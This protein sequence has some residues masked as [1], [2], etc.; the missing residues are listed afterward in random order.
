MVRP[1]LFPAFVVFLH[2]AFLLCV[3][4][5]WFSMPARAGVVSFG[6]GSNIFQMEFV[7]VG[8]PGNADDSSGDP[9]PAGGVAYTFG[10]GKYEVSESMIDKFNNSQSLTISKDTRSPNKPATGVS[11]NE[12]ARFVNWLNTSTGGFAAYKF[13]SGG[14]ND[15]IEL[16]SVS[17]SLDFDTMNPFRSKRAK[18][19]LP[20][21]NEWYKAA[22][23]DPSKSG[24]G[25]YWNYGT[26]S[27]S[28]PIAVASGTAPGTAV[29]NQTHQTGPAEVDKAGGLS[30]YGVMALSGN[31]W[32]W[33]ESTLDLTNSSATLPRG[34]RGGYYYG[35][36][37]LLSS[38]F[39]GSFDP[40][41]E[42]ETLAGFRVVSLSIG[43][44][45]VPEPS[46]LIIVCLLSIG[47]FFKRQTP[48][49]LL[50]QL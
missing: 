4:V 46:S 49:L 30:A 50:P 16:W 12:A 41:E 23:Y 3:P 10:I 34:L 13:T 14:V 22:Y 31:A 33:E 44:T 39:R 2:F 28:I 9:N 17:D 8:A 42:N 37:F 6:S 36:H 32:E 1:S 21:Y 7:S 24:V 43:N 27:D 29:F 47:V 5:F 45:A 18:Y 26:A 19:V 20:S 35:Y 11:W 25:G 48:R 38:S 40:N 15:N